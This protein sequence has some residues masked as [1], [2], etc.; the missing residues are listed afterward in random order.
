MELEQIDGTKPVAYD[1]DVSAKVLWYVN[2]LKNDFKDK[3]L[4]LHLVD[5]FPL[6]PPTSQAVVVTVAMPRPSHSIP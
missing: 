5:D 4:V 6:S 3:P 2:K 1:S